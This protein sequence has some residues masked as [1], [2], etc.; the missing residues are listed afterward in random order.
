MA[1][2]SLRVATQ[3]K[4]A[5]HAFTRANAAGD[6]LFEVRPG[7]PVIDALL[8][9]SCYLASASDITDDLGSSS[10]GENPDRIWGAHYLVKMA[11]AVVDAAIS[12]IEDEER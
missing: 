7:V 9:A 11:K 2:Q 12:A 10:S 8:T 5:R 6:L 4:T 3:R 1:A